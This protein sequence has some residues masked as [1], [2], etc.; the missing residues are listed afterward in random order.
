MDNLE[1]ADNVTDNA[2]EAGCSFPELLN[3]TP[4]WQENGS[5]MAD[6]PT[7]ESCMAATDHDSICGQSTTVV[8]RGYRITCV[9]GD[10][11]TNASNRS[12]RTE[13]PED[14]AAGP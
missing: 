5:D 9:Q 12:N 14:Q 2:T 4:F 7:N 6:T 3:G 11:S 8:Q 1:S 13:I 10:S